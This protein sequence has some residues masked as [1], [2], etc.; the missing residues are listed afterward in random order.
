MNQEIF[1]NRRRAFMDRLGDG[2]AILFAA[3][4]GKRN[5]DV[6]YEYRTCSYFYYLTGVREQEAAAIFLPKSEHPYRLFVMPKNPEMEMWEGKRV[7]VDAAKSVFQA[8]ETFDCHDIER[9]FRE[10]LKSSSSLYHNLG[11][12]HSQDDLIFRALKEHQP[13]PRKGEKKFEKLL[14]VQD[15]LDPMRKVKDSAELEL[16]RKNCKNTAI[17]HRKA[18]EFTRPHHHEYQVEAEIEFWF[19]HGGADDLAYSSIVAGGNNA[20]VLHYKTNRD[21]L[22]DG[23]LLLIDAGGEMDL[24]ASDI[25]RTFPVNG[26][27]TPAQKRIYEIVLRSQKAAIEMVKPGVKFHD[28]HKRTVEVLVQGLMDIGLLHGSLEEIVKDRKNYASFYPH[29]TSHWIGLDVHDCGDYFC[30]DGSSIS[31]EVGNM[32][33]IEPGIYISADRTDVLEEYRGIGI[34]IEDD[35]IV[36]EK[37]CEVLTSDAPKEIAEIEALV[38]KAPLRA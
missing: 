6:H 11:N 32:L 31:L 34:R 21:P 16:I 30:A 18:M 23:D 19:R 10:L 28:I 24:Y 5:S 37:G 1:A 20:T 17:A 4:H 27:F 13:N 26:K 15:L 14:R 8:D 2:M 12:F 36:T 38:G 29:N 3:P 9:V 22:R 35:V 33:T 25:T 7:G